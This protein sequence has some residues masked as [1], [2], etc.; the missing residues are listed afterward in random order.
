MKFR[1][2][3]APLLPLALERRAD[4]NTPS[5]QVGT[6]YF[7]VCWAWTVNRGVCL[8]SGHRH[9]GTE[10]ASSKQC[11]CDRNPNKLPGGKETH[12]MQCQLLRVFPL[13]RHRMLNVC[14]NLLRRF[15]HSVRLKSEH[16]MRMFDAHAM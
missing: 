12:L 10:Q 6:L 13:F 14:W 3:R 11:S 1:R 8:Q 5:L 15:R 16:G 7:H 2:W 4:A 9:I